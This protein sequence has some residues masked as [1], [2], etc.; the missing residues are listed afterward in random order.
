MKNQDDSSKHPKILNALMTMASGTGSDAPPI[1]IL[2]LA[3]NDLTANNLMRYINKLRDDEFKIYNSKTI[4]Y[5]INCDCGKNILVACLA[6]YNNESIKQYNERILKNLINDEQIDPRKIVI[7]WC[8][9]HCIN[10][11]KN[12]TR[13]K[14]YKSEEHN[15]EKRTFSKFAMKMW[16]KIRVNTTLV[17]AINEV[18]NWNWFLDQQFFHLKETNIR[19]EKNTLF[20]KDIF[21][22]TDDCFS[23]ESDIQNLSDEGSDEDEI[24]D[25][26]EVI[27]SSMNQWSYKINNNLLFFILEESGN[28]TI[29]FPTLNMS[30][31]VIKHDIVNRR[32]FN[33]LYNPSLLKYFKSTWWNTILFWSDI[34]PFVRDHA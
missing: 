33:P 10:A 3:T 32:V 12:Y 24:F 11:I 31:K 2:E 1:D 6:A 19:L 9:S 27:T 17:D 8:Y 4:P 28:H 29:N 21:H 16:N 34:I 15:I 25:Y 5:L 23:N 26:D 13:S 14:K 20:I 18:G 30:I 22:F 7:A